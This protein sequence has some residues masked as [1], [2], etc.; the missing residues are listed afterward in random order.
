MLNRSEQRHKHNR[1]LLPVVFFASLALLWA[2]AAVKGPFFSVDTY[3]FLSAGEDF[4]AWIAAE[5]GASPSQRYPTLFP[6]YAI[7]SVILTVIYVSFGLEA[8]GVIFFN[9]TLFALVVCAVFSLWRFVYPGLD[10][11][12]RKMPGLAGVCGGLYVIYGLPDGFLWSYAILT[13][14]MFLFWNVA[15]VVLT[16]RGLLDGNRLAWVL[17]LIVA[18]SAAFVRPPGVILPLLYCFALLLHV[19]PIPHDYI[20]RAGAVIL[21]VPAILVCLVIPWLVTTYEHGTLA[22]D[23]G[24]PEALRRNIHQAVAYFKQG[25]VISNRL[26]MESS[27]PLSYGGAL[28]TIAYRLAYYWIPLRFGEHGYSTIHNTVNGIYMLLALPLLAYG[29]SALWKAGGRLAMAMLFLVA[30]AYGYA[31]LHA[32]TLVSYDWRYQV[33]AMVP[34]WILAGCG[35]FSVLGVRSRRGADHRSG[36][37]AVSA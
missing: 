19:K 23:L 30:T 11:P 4:M 21:A 8:W 28:K 25:I 2:G 12:W 24:L 20:A 6:H 1:L 35:L 17:A 29:V 5:Q 27:M 36:D 16:V 34:L 37:P 14:T 13:D 18:I 32:I 26:E 31:L 3:K 33:P 9:I 22:A 7:S 10:A 15:F